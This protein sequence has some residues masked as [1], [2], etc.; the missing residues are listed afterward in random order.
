MLNR[1]LAFIKSAGAYREED[2]ERDGFLS[3][4][5]ETHG[6]AVGFYYGFVDFRDWNGLPEDYAEG[7]NIETGWYPKAGYVAGAVLRV[8]LYLAVGGAIMTAL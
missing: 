6:L 3:Y 1:L 8:C 2:S 4:S 5:G 7:K